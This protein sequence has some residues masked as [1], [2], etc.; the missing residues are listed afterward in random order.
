MFGASEDRW[1]AAWTEKESG[2]NALQ[3][4]W[5]FLLPYALWILNELRRSMP[6][7]GTPDFFKFWAYTL[8]KGKPPV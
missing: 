6:K 7:Y 2:V 3:T 4:Y 1:D 5:K 8:L